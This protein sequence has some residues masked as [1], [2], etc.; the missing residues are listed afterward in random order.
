MGPTL[1]P[2]QNS[3]ILLIP[4]PPNTMMLLVKP[5]S[6]HPTLRPK[7]PIIFS[8]GTLPPIMSAQHP[9]LSC[10]T[11]RL[12]FPPFQLT[13][14]RCLLLLLA[15]YHQPSLSSN[16]LLSLAVGHCPTANPGKKLSFNPTQEP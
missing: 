15:R 6:P 12:L 16:L 1:S 8:L 4:Q 13:L 7:F 11:T 2:T 3:I 14:A 9:I 5:P 10:L